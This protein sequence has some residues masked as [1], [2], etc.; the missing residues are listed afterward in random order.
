MKYILLHLIK[1]YWLIIPREKR[2]VC[3][4]KISCSLSV[5]QITM[6]QGFIEGIK[7]LLTRFKQCRPGYE[8]YIEKGEFKMRCVD[9][10]IHDQKNISQNILNEYL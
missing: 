10:T 9:G 3:L 2:N 5:Y 4:F 7:V 8:I 6:N 1:L